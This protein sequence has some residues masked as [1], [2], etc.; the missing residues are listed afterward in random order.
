MHGTKSLKSSLAYYIYSINPR[1]VLVV[2]EE[3]IIII[4]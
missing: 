1:R 2:V 4:L 3:N